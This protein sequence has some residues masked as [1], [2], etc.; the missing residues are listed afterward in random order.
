MLRAMPAAGAAASDPSGRG[1]LI[2]DFLQN[3]FHV[4]PTSLNEHYPG[5]SL[6]MSLID[7]ALDR[8]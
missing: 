5:L 3:Q 7:T 4:S 8:R 1:A 2:R 6:L